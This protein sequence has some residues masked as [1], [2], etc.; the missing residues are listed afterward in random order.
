[1]SGA[2]LPLPQ[3]AFMVW[4]LV[5]AHG[6]LYLYLPEAH[7][8]S[9]HSALLHLISLVQVLSSALCVIHSVWGFKFAEV[10][11]TFNKWHLN[12][13]H[14]ILWLRW[15]MNVNLCVKSLVCNF[16]LVMSRNFCKW[17]LESGKVDD[18]E[19]ANAKIKHIIPYLWICFS[20]Y[21]ACPSIL[22]KMIV[23]II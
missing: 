6:Q 13:T 10:K 1:M 12:L 19:I 21:S 4:C 8:V 7:Y 18:G 5:K 23:T 17:N 16:Y 15:H 11:L 9:F 3:Y 2:I 22:F 20:K 14:G